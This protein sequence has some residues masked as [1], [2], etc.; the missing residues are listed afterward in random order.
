MKKKILFHFV[1]ILSFLYLIAYC[2]VC[3]SITAE[4]SAGWSGFV[5]LAIV[6]G[7]TLISRDRNVFAGLS[8]VCLI[9]FL[10]ALYIANRVESDTSVYIYESSDGEISSQPQTIIE[11]WPFT[12]VVVSKRFQNIAVLQYEY[13]TNR[14]SE[15]VIH[16]GYAEFRLAYR[17][18]LVDY[19]LVHRDFNDEK[20]ALGLSYLKK[21]ITS[22]STESE[23]LAQVVD[24]FPF[25]VRI[26]E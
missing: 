6:V 19:M 20:L 2:G 16:R 15:D 3:F 26:V 25:L 22:D 21:Q 18:E 24:S 13:L 12:P 14:N 9:C 10:F 17:D 7:F 4:T 23:V 11:A 5:I 8:V 1:G